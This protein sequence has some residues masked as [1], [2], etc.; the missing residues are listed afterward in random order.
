MREPLRNTAAGSA[1]PCAALGERLW[2]PRA[3]LLRTFA[4]LHSARLLRAMADDGRRLSRFVSHGRACVALLA[5]RCRLLD[6]PPGRRCT[7]LARAMLRP[8]T[9]CVARDFFSCGGRRSA[10]APASLRR[11]RDDWSE[12]F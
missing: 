7:T 1:L 6:A 5:A 4:P 9:P 2:P 3:F 10:A 8:S 12:F 11:C